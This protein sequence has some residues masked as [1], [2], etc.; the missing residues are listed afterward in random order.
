M[1]LA[2]FGGGCFWC[3]E[4][5]FLRIDG[6]ISSV[7]GYMGGE[8]P[9]PSYEQVCSGSTGHVEI[10]QV[11]FEPP[12]TYED[13]LEVFWRNVDPTDDGGQFADR[14]NQYR[15]VIFFHNDVQ[16]QLAEKS[17]NR[18]ADR[19]L[20]KEPIRVAI[21]PASAF[22]KAEEYHC[23]YA[24]KNPLHYQNYKVGSGRHAFLKQHWDDKSS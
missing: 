13:L 20:F 8:V 3:M 2:S 1:E 12:C 4:P 24:E 19:G 11:A 9:N 15:P 5:P 21:E 22:Y 6:V 14:G 16:Q 7:P 18:M 23:N 10:V 17:R